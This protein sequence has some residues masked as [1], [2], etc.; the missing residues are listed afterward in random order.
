[1]NRGLDADKQLTLFFAAQEKLY[2][3]GARNFIFFTVPPFH[4]SPIGYASICSVLMIGTHNKA[5]VTRIEEWNEMLATRSK[6]FHERFADISLAIYDAY[7]VFNRILNNPREN[8]FRDAV[9]ICYEGCI[10]HDHIHPTAKVHELLAAGL[11]AL[12]N[13]N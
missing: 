2:N 4:R 7:W 6:T 13:E 10:W 11:S 12:L 5:L 9:S 1:M 8:G 3:A